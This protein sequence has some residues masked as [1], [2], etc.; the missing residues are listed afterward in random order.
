M[1]RRA[2]PLLAIA[3]LCAFDWSGRLGRLEVDLRSMDPETR[4]AAVRELAHHSPADVEAW[5]LA[6]LE[7]ESE[8]VRL[9]AAA[10][11]SRLGLASAAPTLLSW[12]ASDD[13]L[14]RAAAARALARIRHDGVLAA[15]TRALGDPR[16]SVRA[17]AIEGISGHGE[18]AATAA[19]ALAPLLDDPDAGVRAAAAAAM[20]QLASPESV[21]ALSSAASD[22]TAEVRVAVA[23][24]LG[25]LADLRATSTLRRM[26]AD[27]VADVR[28]AAA[29]GLGRLRAE[30][31]GPEL[32]ALARTV[33][34]AEEREVAAAA[35][36]ALGRLTSTESLQALADAGAR[37][38]EHTELAR[39]AEAALAERVRAR[40]AETLAQL[41]EVLE[42]GDAGRAEW[43]ATVLA[44]DLGARH[45]PAS[46]A[47]VALLDAGRI[48]ADVGLRALGH[49]GGD[50]ALRR[51]LVA[52]D[53]AQ[54][55]GAAL[56]PALAGLA[57]YFA[58]EGAD[59]RAI[60]PLSSALERSSEPSERA[61]LVALLAATRSPRAAPAFVRIVATETDPR[62]RHGALLGLST[63]G[64]DAVTE[65]D[66]SPVE[67]AL[68][69]RDPAVRA[70]AASALGALGDVAALDRAVQA[71][72]ATPRIDRIALTHLV[73]EL[74]RRHAPEGERGSRVATALAARAAGDDA[75]LADAAIDA[76]ARWGG[77]TA[78]DT[79]LSLLDRR[80]TSARSLLSALGRID[81]PRAAQRLAD[82][83]SDGTGEALRAALLGLGE[84]G[85]AEHAALVLSRA[86]DL[87]YPASAAASFALARMARRGVIGAEAVGTLCELVA[88][89]DPIVRANT[90]VA[91]TALG[92]GC[93]GIDPRTWLARPH[94][95]IVRAAAARWLFALG[96]ARP[97]AP[98]AL[99]ECAASLPPRSVALACLEPVL[100]PLDARLDV[101]ALDVD[102]ATPARDA[103]LALLLPDGSVALLRTGADAHVVLEHAPRGTPRLD[104][105]SSLPL[106]P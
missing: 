82:E 46:V 81:D 30:V 66:L 36:A 84:H 74:A 63:M 97:D 34:S 61:E 76:L 56:T 41:T 75:A 7:D 38:T 94:A 96:P 50:A 43:I 23:S 65:L 59:G 48:P 44:T 22:D 58:G 91:L 15:L 18:E 19:T 77:A 35:I 73:A 17:A 32:A 93:P 90:A 92:A 27:P 14:F 67:A 2:V 79:L 8:D 39:T 69:D 98:D 70:S 106:E 64:P 9:D 53:D 99:R 51:L 71:L 52:L 54:R 49:T 10:A 4:A 1:P 13:E 68:G 21:I 102:G 60:E 37:A 25:M 95:A 62:L 47:L 101:V 45:P 87:G 105:P 42:R 29:L 55:G 72:D 100:P 11:A 85:T 78:L 103:E 24:S 83:V 5:V 28:T 89:R 104:R 12:V 57:A 88:L 80:P 26:A 40:P 3:L 86:P 20:G 33:H 16:A 6:A 31:A